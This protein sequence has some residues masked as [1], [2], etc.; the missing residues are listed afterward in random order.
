MGC[1]GLTTV[2]SIES[3]TRP[4][5]Q[6]PSSY[7]I[8]ATMTSLNSLLASNSSLGACT[9]TDGA[10]W[11][12]SSTTVVALSAVN[13]AGITTQVVTPCNSDWGAVV[14]AQVGWGGIG[15]P[16]GLVGGPDYQRIYIQ[17]GF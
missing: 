7:N 2:T 6:D 13:G 11:I 3:V 9:P 17:R 14:E 5:M 4:P 12:K 8:S 10:E 16:G 15:S 1:E